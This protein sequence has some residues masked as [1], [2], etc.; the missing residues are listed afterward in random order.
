MTFYEDEDEFEGGDFFEDDG[1]L[2]VEPGDVDDCEEREQ[3]RW[4]V[5]PC[6]CECI[7]ARTDYP[8]SSE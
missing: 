7:L 1:R 6:C 5:W 8:R 4:A 3:S 2:A